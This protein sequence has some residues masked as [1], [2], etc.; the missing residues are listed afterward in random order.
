VLEDFFLIS[1]DVLQACGEQLAGAV[2]PGPVRV[3][4][5]EEP[6]EICWLA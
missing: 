6:L 1:G 2:P 5:R 3:K 4:G